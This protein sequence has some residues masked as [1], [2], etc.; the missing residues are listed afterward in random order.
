MLA[1]DNSE[2][3]QTLDKQHITLVENIY[4]NNP[5][6]DKELIEFYVINKIHLF[7]NDF[8]TSFPKLAT[9]KKFGNIDDSSDDD[10]EDSEEDI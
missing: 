7:V 4:K 5:S 10:E 9:L 1:E 6:I 2:L 3:K 8:N